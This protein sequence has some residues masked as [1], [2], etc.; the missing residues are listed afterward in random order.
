MDEQI[1]VMRGLMAGG[2]FEHHGELFDI[3]A[4]KMSPTP[5][6]PVPI[7]IGGY[8]EKALQRAARIGDGWVHSGGETP[9]NSLVRMLKRLRKALRRAIRHRE[10]ALRGTRRLIW[11]AFNVDERT[12][13]KEAL[14]SPTTV[15]GFR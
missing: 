1:E 2:Y 11:D 12:P 8:H 14:G 3:P 4:I 6:Q 7:L 13:A 10:Q 5:T 15:V 9:R